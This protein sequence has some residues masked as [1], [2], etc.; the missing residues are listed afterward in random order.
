MRRRRRWFVLVLGGL[1]LSLAGCA[2]RSRASTP[3]PAVLAEAATSGESATLTVRVLGMRSDRGGVAF[4]LYANAAD[5]DSRAEPLRKAYLP[6]AGDDCVWVVDELD[7]GEYA[8]LV[9]HDVNGNRVL[10]RR[11]TFDIPKEPYGFSNDA[12]A[13]FG[14]PGFERARFALAGEPLTIEITLR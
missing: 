3:G 12:S 2:P 1:V 13:P 8:V 4:A 14:P 7:P 6:L 10:D 11:K 9:Y 5:Y